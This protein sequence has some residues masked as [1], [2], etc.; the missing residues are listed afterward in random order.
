[1]LSGLMDHWVP[2]ADTVSRFWKT[3][4]ETLAPLMT[5][6]CD[7]MAV[8][9]FTFYTK[10][11]TNGLRSTLPFL[12][13]HPESENVRTDNDWGRRWIDYFHRRGMTVGA[14][15]QSY[16]YLPNCFP[17][18]HTLGVWKNTTQCTGLAPDQDNIIID[19]TWPG[20]TA[21]FESMLEE[22][23][24]AFPGLDAIFLEFEGLPCVEPTHALAK[25]GSQSTVPD[26]IR[27][28]WVDSAWMVPDRDQWIWTTP[29]QAILKERL[30]AHLS[31]AN[32]VLDRLGYTGIRGVVYHAM[33]YETPYL[34]DALP[35]RNWWLLPW[36]YW[37]WD[38]CKETPDAEVRQQMNWCQHQF[39]RLIQA[40]HPLCYIG[41][42]TLPTE[43]HDSI[44]EM[45]QFCR[46]NGA[47]GHLGMGNPIPTYGL[48]WHGATETSIKSAKSLYQ[49]LFP[50][51]T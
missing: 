39:R 9:H 18:D 21:H 27:A 7:E 49:E 48:R 40:G 15:I 4:F 1:M 47:A 3:P 11:Y 33:S 44:R 43:R 50:K 16:A 10:W 36:H 24:R 41:N 22:Q 17:P 31:A 35:A 5:S 14:M 13:N 26:N 2:S 25:L 20:F 12:P 6:L 8:N 30:Q 29:V 51:L 46:D 32:R 45:V 42:A 19:P 38:F 37:G 34:I 23:L 28:Q